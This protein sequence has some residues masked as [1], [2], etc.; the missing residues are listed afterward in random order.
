MSVQHCGYQF[1][2]YMTFSTFCLSCILLICYFI[3]EQQ[4]QLQLRML[5]FLKILWIFPWLKQYVDI[6]GKVDDGDTHD[7]LTEDIMPSVGDEMGSGEF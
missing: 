7:N 1:L 4:R 2:M 6:E 3:S 5:R